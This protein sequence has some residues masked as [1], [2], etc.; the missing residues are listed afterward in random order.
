MS[1]EGEISAKQA[2]CPYT[3]KVLEWSDEQKQAW[4]DD[5]F[6]LIIDMYM[7]AESLQPEL[8]IFETIK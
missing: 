1:I 5:L 7:D 2:K 6:L 8:P 3:V 4:F